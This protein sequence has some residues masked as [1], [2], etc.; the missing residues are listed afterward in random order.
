MQ[1][2]MNMLLWTT[3]VEESH[4]PLIEQLKAVGYHGIEIPIGEG[5]A[6][7]YKAIGDFLAS[8]DL[9]CTCVTSLL[10]DSNPASADPK[11]RATAL[12][13]LK[14]RIDM[15]AEMGATVIGGPFHSAFAHFSKEPPTADERKWSA[16]VLHQAAEYAAGPGI[17]LTPEAINRF[18]CYLYNTLADI[19]ALIQSVNHPNLR[20]IFDTHHAHIEEKSMSSV[21][22]Q[23]GALFAHVHISENDRGTPGSGQIRWDE[24]F[25][26]LHE[27]GYNG[28]LT[29]E[30]FSRHNPEFA[31]GINVW[32]NFEASLEEIYTDG[33]HFIQEMWDRYA[34]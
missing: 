4:F 19:A 16:E 12:E 33:F 27:I 3:F 31:S 15:A 25:K 7:D 30:A 11:I 22:K 9:G 32:R 13:Q 18:E 10:E 8:Q 1:I 2:G 21:I 23:H 20:L 5:D 24:T 6:K 29:I 14:W 34:N 26:A 17:I 28:W